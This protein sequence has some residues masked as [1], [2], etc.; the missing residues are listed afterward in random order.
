MKIHFTHPNALPAMLISAM[1]IQPHHTSQIRYS[2]CSSY[3]DLFGF[4]FVV[5]KS[6]PDAWFSSPIL[7]P[8]HPSQNAWPWRVCRSYVRQVVVDKLL[9]IMER[10]SV[11]YNIAHPFPFVRFEILISIVSTSLLGD[12]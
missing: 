6:D 11:A 8:S 1:T 5:F 9:K 2:P 7:F 10:E 4:L 12:C 3:E